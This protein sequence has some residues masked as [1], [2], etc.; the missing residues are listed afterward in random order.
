M[1]TGASCVRAIGIV[2]AHRGSKIPHPILGLHIMKLWLLACGAIAVVAARA[3]YT[4]STRQ[5]RRTRFTGD[6]VSS[7]WLAT[8]KIYEDHP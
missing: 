7:E 1:E 8:A 2:L 6:Q 3:V 5:S 4:F